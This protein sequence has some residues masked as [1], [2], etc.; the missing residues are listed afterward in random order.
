MRE[1]LR[2]RNGL[3]N[4]NQNKKSLLDK[5]SGR[6][7]LTQTFNPSSKRLFYRMLRSEYLQRRYSKTPIWRIRK[8]NR[9]L[10]KWLGNIK[11]TPY[12]VFSPFYASYGKNISIGD[13]FF[14]NS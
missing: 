5:R 11:G 14:D 8:R 1:L 3:R 10:R 6:K 2:K 9:I 7:S 13:V 4:T 12:A